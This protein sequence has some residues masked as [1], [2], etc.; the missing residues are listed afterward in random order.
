MTRKAMLPDSGGAGE[1]RGGPG[2]EIVLR[3][4]GEGP[5]M[6]TIRPDLMKYPAPGLHGGGDGAPGD[7]LLEDVKVER[8]TPIEWL[9]G[10]EVILRVPG[11][12]GFGDPRSRPRGDVQED[13]TLGLV[14]LDAARDVYGLDIQLDPEAMRLEAIRRSV[15]RGE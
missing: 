9:P 4:I 1:R 6:L 11:G 2:Q 13:V 12:G 10:Q 8:F 15:M 14:S 5:V 3:H 7:V